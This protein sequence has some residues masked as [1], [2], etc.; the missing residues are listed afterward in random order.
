MAAAGRVPAGRGAPGT[1]AFG[2]A[3]PAGLGVVAAAPVAA[4]LATV[5]GAFA[6]AAGA[7]VGAGVCAIR[8][9]GMNNKRQRIYLQATIPV[10]VARC[11][12]P[13]V[14]DMIG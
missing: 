6:G 1:A 2:V 8:S 10:L 14:L 3:V 13:G 7:L 5:A 4:G 12:T 9:A 11:N